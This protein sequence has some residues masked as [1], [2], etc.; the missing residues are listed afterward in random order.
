M[1]R[2]VLLDLKHMYVVALPCHIKAITETQAG[3]I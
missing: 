2:Y 1:E 3:Y